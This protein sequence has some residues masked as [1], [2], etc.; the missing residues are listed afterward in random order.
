[1]ITINWMY[2]IFNGLIYFVLGATPH[3]Y[4]PRRWS[5]DGV[6]TRATTLMTLK[7]LKYM[8]NFFHA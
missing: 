7:M 2:Y 1:M 6:R 3:N 8:Q 5:K 4:R